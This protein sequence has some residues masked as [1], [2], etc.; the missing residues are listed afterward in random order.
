MTSHVDSKKEQGQNLIFI[1][2]QPRS[3]STLLQVLLSQPSQVVSPPE[4]WLMLQLC[5]PLTDGFLSEDAHTE[6]TR[7]AVK[8]FVKNVVGDAVYIESVRQM[9]LHLYESVLEKEQATYLI[10]KTPRYYYIVPELRQI[11]PQ[12]SIVFLFRNPCAILCSIIEIWVPNGTWHRLSQH[13]DD[14]LLAP[15]K[16]TEEMQYADFVVTYE[17]LVEDQQIISEIH[18]HI[19]LEGSQDLQK[20]LDVP[21]DMWLGDPKINQHKEVVR[22]RVDSW[23]QSLK[24]PQIWRLVDDYLSYLGTDV[25][26]KMGYDYAELR[27]IVQQHQPSWFWRKVTLPLD[28]ILAHPRRSDYVYHPRA[29]LY[30]ACNRIRS[31]F[32][33]D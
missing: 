8:L 15:K 19:G 33:A 29:I 10:D 9:A 7:T 17:A 3:G 31:I 1:A 25:L 14:L 20:S 12:S 28:W 27:L 30:R 26:E 5:R 13:R 6:L 16:L 21:K 32:V 18:Q 23:I 2:S 22:S 11:F 4:M 24:H